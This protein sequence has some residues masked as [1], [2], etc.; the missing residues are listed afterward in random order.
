MMSSSVNE[1]PDAAPV[2][3]IAIFEGAEGGPLESIAQI[4]THKAMF[5]GNDAPIVL[6]EVDPIPGAPAPVV[7][8]SFTG[9]LPVTRSCS[10]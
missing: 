7:L 3:M 1:P 8:K 2:P 4:A 10:D 6:C 9:S 5:A